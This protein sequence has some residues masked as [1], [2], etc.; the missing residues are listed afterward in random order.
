M[1]IKVPPRLT[2]AALAPLALAACAQASP[3]QEALALACQ[4]RDCICVEVTQTI[5]ESGD[6][7]P[8]LWKQNGDAYCQDG[9]RLQLVTDDD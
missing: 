3:S 2:L 6:T 7:A 1:T 5:F 9:Y 8:V 4:T